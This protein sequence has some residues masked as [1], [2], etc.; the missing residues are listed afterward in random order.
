MISIIFRAQFHPRDLETNKFL[1]RELQAKFW[2]V[3]CALCL[4]ILPFGISFLAIDFWMV[5]PGV[6]VCRS[7][8]EPREVWGDLLREVR[9]VGRFVGCWFFFGDEGSLNECF[10][11][12]LRGR[13][14]C[15]SV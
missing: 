11:W 3:N 6:D 13:E 10:L 2:F 9:V 4:E 15:R 5:V 8:F 12:R 14:E 7:A 1:P